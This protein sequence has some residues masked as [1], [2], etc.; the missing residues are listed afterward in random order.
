MSSAI[1][2]LHLFHYAVLSGKYTMWKCTPGHVHSIIVAK[3]D[4]RRARSDP[5]V[6]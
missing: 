2:S 4:N 5:L 3:H 6:I 1:L